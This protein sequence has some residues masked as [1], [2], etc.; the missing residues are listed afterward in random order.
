MQFQFPVFRSRSPP[1]LRIQPLKDQGLTRQRSRPAVSI[2]GVSLE[3]SPQ[4]ANSAPRGSR[5]DPSRLKACSFN[6]RCVARGIAILPSKK[7]FDSREHQPSATRHP[8]SATRHPPS[9]TTAS[10]PGVHLRLKLSP[11]MLSQ[12][13]VKI[14]TCEQNLVRGYDRSNSQKKT[15]LYESRARTGKMTVEE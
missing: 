12:H 5:L 10:C 9:T 3:E 7:P 8:P 15:T 1:S 6:C 2:S 13:V 4:S 11:R 14:Y